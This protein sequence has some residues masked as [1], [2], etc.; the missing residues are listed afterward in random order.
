MQPS[1]SGTGCS[2]N[3]DSVVTTAP[4]GERGERSQSPHFP[5]GEREAQKG[6]DLPEGTQPASFGRTQNG[7]RTTGPSAAVSQLPLLATAISI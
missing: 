4:R 1:G 6:R 2:V 3:A 5:D 7:Y